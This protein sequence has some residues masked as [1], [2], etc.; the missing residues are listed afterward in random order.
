MEDT[1]TKKQLHRLA[2]W[3]I[4]GAAMAWAG[5]IALHAA[6]TQCPA[7]APGD[8]PAPR[9]DNRP[10][11]PPRGQAGRGQDDDRPRGNRPPPGPP[12][13]QRAIDGLDLTAEQHAKVDP[14]LSSFRQKQQQAREEFLKQMKEALTADQFAKIESAMRPPL[15]PRDRQ[16]SPDERHDNRPQPPRGDRNGGDENG[17]HASTPKADPA[18]GV[19]VTLTGGFETDPR[20]HGRPVVLIAAALNVSSDIFRDAFSHVTP[21]PA[22]ANQ[23]RRKSG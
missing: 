8:R 18:L 19:P 9:D 2:M 21:P 12:P 13:L 1:K 23:Q 5:S 10:D 20:D 22:G 11:G 14:I 16:D 15:P 6:Q 17:P 3:V 7:D 4:A